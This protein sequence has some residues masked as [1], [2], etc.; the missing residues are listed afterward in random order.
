MQYRAIVVCVLAGRLLY[1]Q[2]RSSDLHLALQ[3]NRVAMYARNDVACVFYP[4]VLS[5]LWCTWSLKGSVN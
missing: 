3:P 1:R 2:I 4:S 5:W